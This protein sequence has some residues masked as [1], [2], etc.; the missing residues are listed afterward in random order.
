MTHTIGRFFRVTLVATW[1]FAYAA[2]ASAQPVDNIGHARH[3]QK[4]GQSHAAEMATDARFTTSRNSSVPMILPQESDAFSFIVF[5]DRTSGKPEGVSILADA[6]HEANLIEPDF[7][8]NIGDMVQGYN[9]TEQWLEQMREYRGVMAEL[10]CPWFPVAGNHDLYWR[11]D[12]RP[13]REH[14][15]DYE[16]HFGPLW[17]AFEHKNCWFIALCTDEG[18]PETGEKNFR[19]PECQIMSDEQF[20]WLKAT[21]ERAKDADHV[22]VFQHQ[23]RWLGGD[24]YAD[25]WEPVHRLFVEAGNVTAVFAGHIH[26]MR[27]DPRDGIEYVTLAT[28]GGNLNVDSFAEAGFL[29]HFNQVT[30]RKNQI[31]MTAVPVGVTFDPRSVDRK[32]Q[33]EMLALHRKKYENVHVAATFDGATVSGSAAVPVKNTAKSPIEVTAVMTSAD[34]RWNFESRETTFRLEPGQEKELH[35]PFNGELDELTEPPIVSLDV[36]YYGSGKPVALPQ[37]RIEVPLPLTQAP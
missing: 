30:V 32:S 34:G 13:A 19:K 24:N 8:I 25:N 37:K 1:I 18:N 5:G 35:F 33:L 31:G 23:P 22:F 9:T 11:G 27:Y 21:L 14:E 10:K 6:V 16:K 26:Y 3:K 7:V 29:H 15:E 17:Y 12:D 36:T 20:Q 2:I 4:H 28:T